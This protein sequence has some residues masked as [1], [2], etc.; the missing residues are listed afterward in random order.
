MC[1]PI[2]HGYQIYH[3]E[4]TVVDYGMGVLRIV[5]IHFKLSAIETTQAIGGANPNETV[6]SLF[7]EP[8]NVSRQAI[9]HGKLRPFFKFKLRLTL[10]CRNKEHPKSQPAHKSFSTHNCLINSL[11]PY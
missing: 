10:C 3:T 8:D 11:E 2:S 4:R 6:F 1:P 9:F 5:L 7:D